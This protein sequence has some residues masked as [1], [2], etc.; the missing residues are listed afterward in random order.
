MKYLD[1]IKQFAEVNGDVKLT[2]M[3]STVTEKVTTMRLKMKF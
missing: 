3:L 2:N 1:N